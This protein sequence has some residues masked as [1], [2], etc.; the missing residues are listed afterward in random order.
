MYQKRLTQPAFS[1]KFLPE[2]RLYLTHGLLNAAHTS[3]AGI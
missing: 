1:D 2:T 3:A